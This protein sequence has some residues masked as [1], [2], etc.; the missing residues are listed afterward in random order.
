MSLASNKPLLRDLPPLIATPDLPGATQASP[1]KKSAEPRDDEDQ[2]KRP[3][4]Q[5]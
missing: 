4:A 5:P 3:A 1:K 2:D